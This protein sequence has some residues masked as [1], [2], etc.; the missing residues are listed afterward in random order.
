MTLPCRQRTGG[1]RS[2]SWKNGTV[3]REWPPPADL[4]AFVE[5]FWSRRM[6]AEGGAHV[7]LPDGHI[8]VLFELEPQARGFVVGAMTRPLD[9]PSRSVQILA[10]RFKPGAA[11]VFIGDDAVRFN[12]SV[13][14]LDEVRRD[15][16]TLAARLAN[17][18]PGRQ[19]AAITAELRTIYADAVIPGPVVHAT[20]HLTQA[21]SSIER[22][23]CRELGISRQSLA[24]EF[25][26][27]VGL[28][29][30][31]FAAVMRMQRAVAALRD[32][33]SKIA[34]VALACGYYDQAHMTAEMKR[35]TGKPPGLLKVASAQPSL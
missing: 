14:A 30:K 15:G 12:D 13:V 33:A 19:A 18:G 25:R 23:V 6:Y 8:D 10:V 3:Y 21:A 24:R 29:P 31:E 22:T 7:V 17:A 26:R 5:C 4:E 32:P 20:R 1:E 28:T 11:S 16:G 34:T 9:V 27:H 35:F 2:T